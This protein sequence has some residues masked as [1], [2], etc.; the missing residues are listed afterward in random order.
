MEINSDVLATTPREF[1]KATGVDIKTA[2]REGSITFDR[3]L[4][5]EHNLSEHALYELLQQKSM[6]Y[7]PESCI[8]STLMCVF[9]VMRYAISTMACNRLW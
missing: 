5:L 8:L 6:L 4:G 1:L 7:T 3:L 9:T 2:D